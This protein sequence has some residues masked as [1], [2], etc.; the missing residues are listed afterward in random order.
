[1]TAHAHRMQPA[2][3][4]RRPRRVSPPADGAE[5]EAPPAFKSSEEL[6]AFYAAVDLDRLRSEVRLRGANK[7]RSKRFINPLHD[8]ILC[9]WAEKRL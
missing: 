1:M 9:F 2:A 3:P 7:A 4:P 5:E 6:H 8:E